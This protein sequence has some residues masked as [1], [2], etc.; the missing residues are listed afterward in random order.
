MGGVWIDIREEKEVERESQSEKEMVLERNEGML[1][2][3]NEAHPLPY[4]EE[5]IYSFTR[6]TPRLG[7]GAGIKWVKTRPFFRGVTSKLQLV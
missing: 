4:Q 7:C 1:D 2:Q 5:G 3:R 6:E